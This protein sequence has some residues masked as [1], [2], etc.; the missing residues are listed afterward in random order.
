MNKRKNHAKS[1]YRC[2][3]IRK[4]LRNVKKDFFFCDTKMYLKY[5]IVFW[6][7]G[8]EM[9]SLSWWDEL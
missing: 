6:W 1:A 4:D 9:S 3:S 5:S 8:S 2:I 7:L